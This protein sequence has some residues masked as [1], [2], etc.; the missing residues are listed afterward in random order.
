MQSRTGLTRRARTTHL[1][2]LAGDSPAR[3]SAAAQPLRRVAR[4]GWAG[5]RPLEPLTPRL[6]NAP[7][8]QKASA[9]PVQLAHTSCLS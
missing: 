7:W 3:C 1:L 5:C 9:A 2:R 6:S 8:R 4:S